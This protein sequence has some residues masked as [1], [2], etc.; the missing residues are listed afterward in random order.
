MMAAIAFL[1]EQWALGLY[2]LLAGLFVLLLWR[3]SRAT[4]EYRATYFELE[5]E[6][7]RF[8]RANLLTGMVLCLEA[9]LIV[10]GVQQ[11]VAPH[12][13]E[14]MDTTVLVAQLQEDG[15]FSTPTPQPLG[16]FS[17]DSSGVVLGEV[18][19]ADQ[20]LPTPTLTPTPVGTIVPNSPAPVGCD[21]PNAQ[22]QIPANGQI[23]FNP[24]VVRGVAYIENFAFYRLELR[25]PSTFGNWA[26]LPGD[27]DQPI[28]ELSELGQFNPE[29]E[30]GE[31][32]FRLSVFDTTAT[33]RVSCAVTIY[34]SEPIPTATPLG[35]PPPSIGG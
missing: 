1:I 3:L 20:I 28:T 9:G 8:Q 17:I 27:G 32:Q 34:I 24:I 21:T 15:S 19:P 4:R 23:V 5:R 6:M 31:Y 16:E 25:G 33:N 22:L 26:P 13:R 29:Y 2:A 7:V 14:T 12:L 30:P 11:V 18:N 35:T 10:L